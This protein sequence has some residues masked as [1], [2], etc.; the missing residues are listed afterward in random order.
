MT[1]AEFESHIAG[2]IGTEKYTRLGFPFSKHVL[3]DGALWVAQNGATWL[4]TDIAACHSLMMRHRDTRLHDMQIWELTKNVTKGKSQYSHVLRCWAD[5]G[6]GEKPVYE[7]KYTS[8]SI[9]VDK[10]GLYV[11][12]QPVDENRANDLFVIM[13]QGEY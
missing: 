5:T 11:C 2:F 9:P 12:R 6:E 13:L 7:K 4:M 1:T 10:F 8:V 3:T